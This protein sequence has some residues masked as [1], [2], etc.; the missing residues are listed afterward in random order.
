MRKP[1]KGSLATDTGPSPTGWSTH[2]EQFVLLGERVEFSFVIA[3]SLRAPAPV[4]PE[5]I[6]AYCLMNIGGE[7]READLSARGHFRLVHDFAAYQPGNVVPV[8]ATAY[9]QR[10]RRDQMK[11]GDRWVSSEDPYNQRDSQIAQDSIILHVYA[12]EVDLPVQRPG[13]DLD[14]AGGRLEIRRSDGDAREIH[15]ESRQRGGFRY[16]GP[17]AE[18]RYRVLYQPGHHEVN[19][20]GVTPIRFTARDAEGQRHIT[21]AVINTP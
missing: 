14:M 8:V 9:Q 4:S 2:D 20:Q 12:C 15:S 18:D 10:G 11:I 19:K 21:E 1:V 7:L 17:D 5:S 16:S 6:G 3:R 13:R